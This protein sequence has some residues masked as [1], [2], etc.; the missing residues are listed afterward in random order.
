MVASHTGYLDPPLVPPWC[1]SFQRLLST[2]TPS[3][4]SALLTVVQRAPTT[5]GINSVEAWAH[6]QGQVCY[7]QDFLTPSPHTHPAVALARVP[8]N[9]RLW[10]A[11]E[12]LLQAGLSAAPSTPGTGRAYRLTLSITDQALLIIWNEY[13]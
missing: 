12:C 10:A 5:V 13:T 7:Y 4:A 3:V 8:I 2:P 6:S 9:S 11:Q 1:I